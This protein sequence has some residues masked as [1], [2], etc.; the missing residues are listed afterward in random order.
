M[1]LA[2]LL[3]TSSESLRRN[4]SR[5]LL[6]I[7]GV[8]I[9]IA[10]VILM[11][12]I[13]QSAEGY[14]LNQVSDLGSDLI[15]IEPSSGSGESGP[16]SMY[17]EQTL[18][19]DDV[20]VL[21]KTGFFAA[22]SPVLASSVSLSRGEETKFSQ[23]AGVNET[24]DDIFSYEVASGRF[25]EE[26]DIDAYARVVVLGKN[27]AEDLFGDQD[28][29]GQEIKIKKVSFRVI[30][31]FGEL[32]SQ[33][34]Q[35][36]DEQISIPVTTAQR[37]ILGVDYVSYLVAQAGNGDTVT[38]KEEAQFALRES[39]NLDNPNGDVNKDDFLVSTQ[40]DAVAIIG[41]V[42]SVLSLLLASIA[43]ISLV[44]GGIGIM[45]IMLVSVT[46][47]T[48][49][50][51]LRKAVGA[52]YKEILNQFLVEAVML[53]ALGGLIGIVFGIATSLGS[54]WIIGKF[55]EGWNPNVPWSGVVLG[56]FVSTVVGII[57]G[58]YPAR[59]A[60]KLDP[61]EALRYE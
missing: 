60:A 17:V 10:S 21:Q 53:T 3:I 52:T 31:V 9:G 18:D 38:A 7:L 24:Y 5:S 50:I 41:A 42:G 25:F 15:F 37:D 34:F 56:F 22:V 59:H 29:L 33:F 19:L 8:V 43:A 54:A 27:V 35:N 28:P 12:A 2:D 47:R 39:H 13:G 26:S 58:I 51:G 40:S 55:V 57:F 44:V 1:R 61:I 20:L 49:E 32:G 45:N 23:F 48:K 30:G 46:E 14:I 16:P 36:L 11:L 4:K 6:T